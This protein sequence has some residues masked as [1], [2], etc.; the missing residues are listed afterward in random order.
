MIGN[1]TSVTAASARTPAHSAAETAAAKL[2][3][4]PN[5][6]GKDVAPTGE[7]LPVTHAAPP[8]VDVA[9]AVRRLNELMEQRQRDLSFHVD[10]ASGRTV[11]TVRDAATSEVVRQIPS[12]EVLALARVLEQAD[13]RLD[14]RI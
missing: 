10:E 2:R 8:P 1:L 9:A 5:Q 4:G 13:G 6:G 12:E 14:A 3:P 11:I 7:E